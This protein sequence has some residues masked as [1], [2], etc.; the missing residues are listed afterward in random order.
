VKNAFSERI[1][2]SSYVFLYWFEIKASF[3]VAK[4][5]SILG[6]LKTPITVAN[7]LLVLAPWSAQRINFV[8]SSL[9]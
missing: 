6:S 8:V 2:S 9:M 5:A 4:T 1:S 3:A 7:A